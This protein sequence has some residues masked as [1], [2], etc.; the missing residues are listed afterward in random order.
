ME[1]KEIALKRCFWSHK[2][3]KWE[4]YNVK[5]LANDMKTQYTIVKQRRYCVVCGKME[6]EDI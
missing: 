2:W 3:T 1:N 5:M 6:K 4:L